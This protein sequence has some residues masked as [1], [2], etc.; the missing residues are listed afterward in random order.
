E[1]AST[2]GASR[3]QTF[4]RVSLPLVRPA[5]LGGA[6][7][8]FMG[9]VSWF[10]IPAMLGASGGQVPVLATE[11]F[12]AVQP[13]TGQSS[14]VSY[15]AAGVYGILIAVPSLVALYFYYRVLAQSRRYAVVSGKG[16]Q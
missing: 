12:Y 1:A 9:A 6:I 16:F 14:L 10:E 7:Y 4:A 5:L 8:I 2:S 15:G 3:W 11:L 13:L